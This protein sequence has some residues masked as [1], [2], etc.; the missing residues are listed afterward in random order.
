MATG[1]IISGR[2][3]ALNTIRAQKSTDINDPIS[4]LVGDDYNSEIVWPNTDADIWYDEEFTLVALATKVIDL[5]SFT[6]EQGSV[7][8]LLTPYWI[9]IRM[10]SANL[11]IISVGGGSNPHKKFLTPIENN[12]KDFILLLNEDGLIDT[13]IS[14]NN[15]LFDNIDAVNSNTFRITFIGVNN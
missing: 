10:S 2:T 9:Q 11:G 13:T 6:N 8:D 3:S 14:E 5:K 15:I 12:A 4:S 1:I 7:G